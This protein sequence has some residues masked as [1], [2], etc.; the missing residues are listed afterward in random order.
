MKTVPKIMVTLGAGLA[1]GRVQGV[2]CAPDNGSETPRKLPEGRER[3][4]KQVEEEL[5]GII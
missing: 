3:W 2:L 1:I 5:E 4:G